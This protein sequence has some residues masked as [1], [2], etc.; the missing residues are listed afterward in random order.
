MGIYLEP[1]EAARNGRRI[2]TGS[3]VSMNAQLMSGEVLV[4]LHDRLLYKLAP[5]IPDAAELEEFEKQYRS[6]NLVSHEFY[7]VPKWW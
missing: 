1:P 7:A 4:G 3:F 6:G 5:Y 2:A